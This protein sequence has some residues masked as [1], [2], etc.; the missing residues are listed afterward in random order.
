MGPATKRFGP[1]AAAVAL[2]G[3]L[4]GCPQ[5]P[6]PAIVQPDETFYIG[7]EACSACHANYAATHARTGHAQALKPVLDGPPGYP[8]GAGVP[9]PPPGLAW[10]QVSYVVGG[11][12]KGATFL[13]ASGFVLTTGTSGIDAK[14]DQSIPPLGI[15]AGFVQ[16]LP[17]QTTPLPFAFSQ[18]GRRAT[19]AVSIADNGGLR[20]DNRP[21]IEGTWVQ[22]GVQCEAC[23]G[24]GS[25]HPADPLGGTIQRAG[26]S[27]CVNCHSNARFSPGTDGSGVIAAADGLISGFQQ[28][29]ELAA[30][31]H[32]TFACTYCHDPHVSVA[33]DRS[34]A[35]R[36]E[37]QVC[38]FDQNM[39][40][41]EG[42]VFV[43][44]DYVEPVTCASCHMPYAVQTTSF[45]DLP[46]TNGNTA[47]LG[48]TRSHIFRLDPGADSL[49]GMFA[50]GGT[51]VTVDAQGQ[52]SVSTCFVCQ[53]CHT[54]QGNAFA[55]PAGEGCAFGAGI[56]GN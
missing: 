27:A 21:G 35:I 36:N 8:A 38:H 53:R 12:Q 22:T 13:D 30:S 15:T 31:P 23:H 6:P 32:S 17:G 54:G 26:A 47:R 55:F 4:A 34:S 52:A 46:L 19:G 1:A 9:D 48:D 37:C 25:R 28:S 24:P 51:Q 2:A 39:A 14:Y 42:L 45:F 3:L 50:A 11:Y 33:Y 29:T 16:H 5:E 43:R 18:F 10:S 49:A 41:H 40:L 44:G 7:P 20:Q 56:H